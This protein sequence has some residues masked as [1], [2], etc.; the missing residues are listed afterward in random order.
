[1]R[2]NCKLTK[3]KTA[4]NK[5]QCDERL[6]IAVDGRPAFEERGNSSSVE[7]KPVNVRGKRLTL[8]HTHNR[9]SSPSLTDNISAARFFMLYKPKNVR[10]TNNIIINE[11]ELY[12]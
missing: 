1:M 3:E 7:A 12:K 8:V 2:K 5:E 11:G 6:V 9:S 4:C 10:L